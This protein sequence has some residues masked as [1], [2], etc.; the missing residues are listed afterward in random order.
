MTNLVK[1]L[2]VNKNKQLRLFLRRNPQSCSLD[3]SLT[4]LQVLQDSTTSELQ[5]KAQQKNRGISLPKLRRK[6]TLAIQS[7][8]SARTHLQVRPCSQSSRLPR[9]QLKELRSLH[10]P[11]WLTQ[12]LKPKKRLSLLWFRTMCTKLI[13]LKTKRRGFTRR[14]KCWITILNVSNKRLSW[15]KSKARSSLNSKTPWLTN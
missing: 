2:L 8:P 11:S 4:V 13:L 7:L 15:F 6:S 3:F 1:P 10:L 12:M 5:I 14:R 9:I